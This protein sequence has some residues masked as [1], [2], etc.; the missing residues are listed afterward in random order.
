MPN[1]PPEWLLPGETI[2]S[3][4]RAGEGNM[5]LTRRVRT[6]HR[7]FIIK[8][9]H[10]YV[11]K[12]PHIPAPVER[13]EMEARFYRAVSPYAG[14]ARLMPR[15]LAYDAASHTL[16]L[17]D[18]GEAAD[19]TFLYD[20]G[21][22]AASELDTLIGYLDALA[23]VH[24]D[25]REF[26][27]RAMRQLNHEHIFRFPL[28]PQNGL[29]LDAITPGL[30]DAAAELQHD[31]AYKS[32]VAA[33]GEIYLADGGTLVHGDYFPGSWLRTSQGLKIIDPEFCFAGAPEFDLGVLIAHLHLACEPREVFGQNS[34]ALAFAGVEIM[35]RLIG[36]AQLTLPYGL[37]VKVKLLALSRDLVLQS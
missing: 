20:G 12:Y 21:V 8:Q 15:L 28:D 24:A 11:E 7:C 3:I 14:V 6:S 31:S 37:E 32:R 33:L 26:S 1:L 5:N 25:P 16:M 17:E 29:D 9:A 22:L 36:V 34:L 4:T 30:R 13:A 35:R 27:N 18:L 10:P 2:E 19:C 23:G